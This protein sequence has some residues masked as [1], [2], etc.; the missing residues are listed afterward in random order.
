MAAGRIALVGSGEY[1]PVMQEVEGWLLDGRP[2]RYVQLATAAAPEGAASLQH[3]HDLGATAAQR[4]GVEQVVIDVRT[5]PDAEQPEWADA[6]AGAGLVYLSGGNPMH[7]VRTL[8]GTAVWRAI[9]QAWLAG[10]SLA[11]CSAGAMALAG[12]VPDFRHPRR[13]GTEGLGVVPEIRVLPHFDR[14]ARWI[15]D[16]AMRPLVS[17][18]H[19]VIGI[20]E[21]TA[22]LGEPAESPTW[23][24]RVRGRQSAWRIDADRRHRINSPVD[25]RVDC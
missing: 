6:I 22:L 14:Y 11:G 24:F 23:S 1:L 16:F 19:L 4:L 17:P 10:A 12:Y 8:Q 15:P 20:D 9:R 25:L 13:G 2:G 5:R 21:D 7:L 18:A 3:W